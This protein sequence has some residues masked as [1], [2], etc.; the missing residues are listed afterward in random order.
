M[1]ALHKQSEYMDIKLLRHI[2]YR[3]EERGIQMNHFIYEIFWRTESL[4]S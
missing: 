4:R 3:I 1:C 2:M